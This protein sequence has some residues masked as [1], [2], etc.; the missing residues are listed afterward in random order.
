MPQASI[1]LPALNALLLTVALVV[2]FVMARRRW[3]HAG[4]LGGRCVIVNTRRPDDQS[5]RGWVRSQHPDGT[6]ELARA[7]YLE[8]GADGVQEVAAGDVW[9]PAASISWV[10]VDVPPPAV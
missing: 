10:Q 2:A 8:P 4:E 5:V 3:R 6:L 7:V 1:A 9:I